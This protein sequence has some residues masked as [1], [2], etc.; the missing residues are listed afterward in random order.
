MKIMILGAD[1]YLGWPTS[2]DLSSKNHK[3]L[4]IDNFM[5]KN[6][7]KEYHRQPLLSNK[8]LNARI[9]HLNNK[10]VSFKNINC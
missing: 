3:L 7:L 2:V 8:S 6:L 4:L 10:N 9:K 1:G 5:K